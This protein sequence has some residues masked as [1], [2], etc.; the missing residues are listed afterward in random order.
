M[1]HALLAD[2]QS[3]LADDITIY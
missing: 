3:S 1:S 2:A